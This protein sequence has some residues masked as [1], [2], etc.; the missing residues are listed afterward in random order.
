MNIDTNTTY[1]V[2]SA[3]LESGMVLHLHPN[4]PAELA[5]VFH[6]TQHGLV[7][8]TFKETQHL[9]DGTPYDTIQ[10]PA[11]VTLIRYHENN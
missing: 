1:Q 9:P 6:M 3:A 11:G 4:G 2:P 10:V 8:V 7:E 5:H